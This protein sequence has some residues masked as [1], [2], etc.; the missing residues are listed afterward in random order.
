M[1]VGGGSGRYDLQKKIN[2]PIGPLGKNFSRNL[3]TVSVSKCKR[4]WRL[5]TGK[6]IKVIKFAVFGIKVNSRY[7]RK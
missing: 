5:P 1:F 2:V 4:P 3:F 7:L 6:V